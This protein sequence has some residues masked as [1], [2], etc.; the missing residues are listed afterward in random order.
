MTDPEKIFF[1][2]QL[3]QAAIALIGQRINAAKQVIDEAQQAVNQEEKSSSGDKYETGRAMG[4]LQKDMFARQ[5]A[6]QLKELAALHAINTDR[7]YAGVTTGAYIKCQGIGFFIAVGLGKQIIDRQI[8]F[9]LSPHAPLAGSL[10]QK[11][12]GDQFLFN[13]VL[14]TIADVY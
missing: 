4:H 6:E 5:M 12:A 10:Q 1:K 3:K 9:F 14:T 7:V 2:N 13:S 11:K 8:I